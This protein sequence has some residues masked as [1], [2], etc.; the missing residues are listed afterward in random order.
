MQTE[1]GAYDTAARTVPVTFTDGAVV[2]TRDVNACLTEAGLYDADAT[3]ARVAEVALGV[4]VKI[5]LGVI[6]RAEPA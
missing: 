1:I 4:A 5:G 3:A 6:G 2:Y